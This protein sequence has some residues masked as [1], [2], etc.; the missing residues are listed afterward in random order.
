MHPTFA[1]RIVLRIAPDITAAPDSAF[2][3]NIAYW[4]KDFFW[5]KILSTSVK[6]FP[7]TYKNYFHLILRLFSYILAGKGKLK[8][9]IFKFFMT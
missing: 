9:E 6:M 8:F 5:D 3:P 4:L 2:T 7:G 1:P